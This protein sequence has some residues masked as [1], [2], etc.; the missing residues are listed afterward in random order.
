MEK[1]YIDGS[2]FADMIV[3][4]AANLSSNKTAVNDLNVFPIPDGDTGDNMFMTIESGARMPVSYTHLTLPT[5][6]RV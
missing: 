4:G 6:E 1:N 3:S 5:T 2:T